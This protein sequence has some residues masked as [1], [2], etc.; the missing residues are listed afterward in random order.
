MI[1][2][3]DKPVLLTL[4]KDLV[5]DIKRG[6]PW[7]YK[8]SL[9]DPPSLEKPQL[10]LLKYRRE[11]VAYGIYDPRSP[12][13]FRVLS[14]EKQVPP[15]KWGFERMQ[16]AWDLRKRFLPADTTGFRAC[17]GEG[18]GLPGLVCD[19]YDQT[20]VLQLDGRG[21]EN[22]WNLADIAKWLV[23]TQKMA[24]VFFKARSDSGIKSQWLKNEGASRVRFRENGAIFEA[25]I[26]HGQKTG[27]FFDQR[28]NRQFVGK[29]SHDLSVLNLFSYTGGFSVYAARGG[30]TH[31][32]S[33]DIADPATQNC[34]L[35]FELNQL[36]TPHEAVSQDA[37]HFLETAL[38]SK[39]KW[40]LVV[41][42]PPS[43]AP[44]SRLVE[45]AKLAY[46]SIF[47][48]AAKCVESRGYLAL[49]SC[50]SHITEQQLLEVTREALS[51]ARRR[52]RLLSIRNQPFDH[53]F[54]LACGELRYLKFLFLRLED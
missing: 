46:L 1:I 27:F 22:F 12:L 16:T 26:E 20:A 24:H 42:D 31:V 51:K 45:K 2:V 41:V 6:H 37:F 10:G 54:P 48:E 15:K 18:D 8:T 9:K 5:R 40:G 17:N 13:A 33:V 14:V 35:N 25:D 7:V 50:S 43:F 32:T 19:V 3:D 53:P 11:E 34:K 28:D 44:N 49:S 29:A 30:A 36:S 38:L 4:A 39:Q 47:S 52:G 23:D 21:F